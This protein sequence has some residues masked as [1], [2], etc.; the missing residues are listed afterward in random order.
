MGN[1]KIL[2]VDDDPQIL[3]LYSALLEGAGYEVIFQATECFV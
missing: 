1:K 2:I 3:E